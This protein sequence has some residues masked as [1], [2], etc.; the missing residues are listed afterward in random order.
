MNWMKKHS[1]GILFVVGVSLVT[2]GIY[3]IWKALKK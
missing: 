1:D 2:L 3:W